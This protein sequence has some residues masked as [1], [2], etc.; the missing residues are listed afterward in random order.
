ME[1]DV[2]LS[3]GQNL[4]LYVVTP[5]S[6]HTVIIDVAPVRWAQ[7]RRF[8]VEFVKVQPASQEILS[9]WLA[10]LAAEGA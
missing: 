2:S 8:G 10:R 3:P 7:G 4:R 1:S 6:H 5:A 9:Q